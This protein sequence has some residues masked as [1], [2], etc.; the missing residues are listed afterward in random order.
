M[1]SLARILAS[2]LTKTLL[3]EDSPESCTTMDLDSDVNCSF[4]NESQAV[5]LALVRG[6][7]GI[8]TFIA[9]MAA[10]LLIIFYQ[11]VG[12]VLQ[13]L[14]LCNTVPTPVSLGF[15]LER[16]YA[17]R[18]GEVS[19]AVRSASLWSTQSGWSF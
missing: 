18:H 5:T 13:R 6:G 12:T 16:H 4:F 2:K 14:F 3:R 10:L 7:A 15:S 9:N 17:T 11:A 8:A 19:C 1:K